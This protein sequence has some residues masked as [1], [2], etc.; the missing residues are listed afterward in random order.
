MQKKSYRRYRWSSP[1]SHPSLKKESILA[2]A[3]IT[4]TC[5]RLK[6]I[7]SPAETHPRRL[8]FELQLTAREPALESGSHEA[9]K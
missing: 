4:C 6:G 8:S 9:G 7:S 2:D 3:L 1:H 5:H